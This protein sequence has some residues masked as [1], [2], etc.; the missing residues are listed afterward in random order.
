MLT[1]IW[2]VLFGE[3][4][5]ADSFHPTW[6]QWVRNGLWWLRNPCPVLLC[7]VLGLVHRPHRVTAR[8]YHAAGVP[9]WWPPQGYRVN[10]LLHH[11]R[12]IVLPCVIYRGRWVEGY[13]GWQ[14]AGC[15]GAAF[16]RTRARGY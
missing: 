3:S 7:S 16:R 8:F 11:Y 6:P 15:L 14:Y 5:P 1:R 4:T 2:F 12:G 13:L 10:W 9:C